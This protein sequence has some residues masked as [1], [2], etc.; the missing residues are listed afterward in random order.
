MTSSLGRTA[1]VS[2]SGSLTGL[3][4]G[5][6]WFGNFTAGETVLYSGDVNDPAA[7]ASALTVNFNTAVRGVGLQITSAAVPG[8][9]CV[10]R[11][12]NA[13]TSLGLFTVSGIMTGSR[14]GRRHSSAR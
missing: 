6:D 10:P 4:E 13:P 9:R 12:F 8:L 7:A 2:D 14:T 11:V 3:V 1:S 5:I